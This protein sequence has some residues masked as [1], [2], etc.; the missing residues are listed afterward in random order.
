MSFLLG[1]MEK[2]TPEQAQSVVHQILDLLWLFMEV[3]LLTPG[4]GQ[5]VRLHQSKGGMVG[6]WK[7]PLSCC[8]SISS[9]DYEVQDCLKQLMM[10]LL[11]L[12]R[13]SP[14][15]PDLGLQVGA[16]VPALKPPSLAANS[17]HPFLHRSTTCASLFLS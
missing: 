7:R 12:Y 11:R 14:I 4:S 1:I 16:S 10:S 2:G 9:Q 3:R 5:A 15:V 13:F 8:P 6:S 17:E